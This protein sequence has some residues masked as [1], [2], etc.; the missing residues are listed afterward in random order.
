MVLYDCQERGK[1]VIFLLNG[2]YC[3][4]YIDLADLQI[5]IPRI[6]YPGILKLMRLDLSLGGRTGKIDKGLIDN[7]SH[8]LTVRQHGKNAG[9]SDIFSQ[10][11]NNL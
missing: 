9:I 8:R 2:L 10:I 1:W 3:N 5:I 6:R 7:Y 11:T 4:E